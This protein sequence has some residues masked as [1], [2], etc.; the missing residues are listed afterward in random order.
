MT[1]QFVVGLTGS[2]GM[3]KSTT[4][5]MFSDLDI[6]VWDADAAVNRLYL[7]NGAGAGA[8]AKLVP[9]A[10]DVNGVD[11]T[12]LKTL[13]QQ[14]STLLGKIENLIHPLVAL[15]RQEFLD[16]H[17]TSEIVLLDI[18]LLFE[19]GS[20]DLFDKIV[21][22]SVSAHLQRER[23]LA[24]GTMNETTFEMILSKQL[25]DEDKRARADYIIETTTIE[26]ARRQV[27]SIV[28]DLRGQ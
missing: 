6:P 15:D 10:V 1:R 17:K 12:V 20:E 21:V 11:R 28:S 13:I 4:A 19:K 9:E 7:R 3:G 5:K 26:H 23:V 8:I 16:S 22:V 25:A 27:H 24:R 18:P 14:D 2:I